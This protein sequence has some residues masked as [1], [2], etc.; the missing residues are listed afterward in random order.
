M[1]FCRDVDIIIAIPKKTMSNWITIRTFTYT[2]EA[3]LAKAIL[4]SGGI[5]VLLK[6]EF[7]TQVYS[8]YSTAIGG[9]KLQ[10]M[11]SDYQ[12]AMQVLTESGYIPENAEKSDRITVWFDKFTSSIPL[13]GKAAVKIRFLILVAIIL[14][15]AVVTCVIINLPSRSDML[16]RNNWCV[17]EILYGGKELI[18]NTDCLFRIVYNYQNCYETMSFDKFGFVSLPGINS[19]AE[20][21]MWKLKGDSLIIFPER[22]DYQTN[23][24]NDES[25]LL[26]TRKTAGRNKRSVYH[27]TYLLTIRN[28]KIILR[29]DSLAI[30]GRAYIYHY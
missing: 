4:E 24:E 20:E 21:A 10:V 15:I 9:V 1:Y 26:Y 17:D 12:D 2:H 22:D 6:D 27:G 25:S 14:T 8:F 16:T 13:I 23:N 11:D 18:P 7:I 5:E 28:N 3:Q 30:I 19:R 29:S